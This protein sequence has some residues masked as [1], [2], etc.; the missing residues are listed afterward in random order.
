MLYK[1]QCEARACGNLLTFRL[2]FSAG[3]QAL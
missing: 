2:A 3:F 1:S